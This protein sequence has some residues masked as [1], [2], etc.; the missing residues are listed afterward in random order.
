MDLS[1][2]QEGSRSETKIKG[3]P[4][5]SAISIRSQEMLS[6][7]RVWLRQYYFI[8]PRCCW[9]NREPSVFR[10]HKLSS[11]QLTKLCQIK[12]NKPDGF[13]L[14]TQIIQQRRGYFEPYH[15]TCTWTP[16]VLV[17][18]VWLKERCRWNCTRVNSKLALLWEVSVSHCKFSKTEIFLPFLQGDF[19]AWPLFSWRKQNRSG[20]W[21]LWLLYP[22]ERSRK[23][24]A[25]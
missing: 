18:T 1:K 11:Q 20:H 9:V 5:Q 8:Q 3:Y 19:I 15:F 14:P 12:L 10:T 2:V 4:Q 23:S 21:K 25:G 7:S 24:S 6:S 17:I 16:V 13:F 22:P